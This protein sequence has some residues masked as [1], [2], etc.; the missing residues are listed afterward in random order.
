MFCC[1]AVGGHG[2]GGVRGCCG[3]RE[4]SQESPPPLEETAAVLGGPGSQADLDF[5]AQHQKLIHVRAGSRETYT[6][7][8]HLPRHAAKERQQG[9]S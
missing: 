7:V 6:V 1:L 5:L 2:L 8:S 9:Q 3:E 4:S